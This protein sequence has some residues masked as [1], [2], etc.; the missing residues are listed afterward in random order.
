MGMAISFATFSESKSPFPYY[1]KLPIWG[2]EY[3][4]AMHWDI[5]QAQYSQSCSKNSHVTDH[6]L[7]LLKNF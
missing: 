5:K 6:I 1:F 3:P 2:F 7:L 4:I